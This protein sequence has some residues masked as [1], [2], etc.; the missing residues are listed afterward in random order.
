[1][2]YLVQEVQSVAIRT[3]YLLKK[4]VLRIKLDVKN[5]WNYDK[6]IRQTEHEVGIGRPW[7]AV[8]VSEER[9]AAIFY[10]RDVDACSWKDA[11]FLFLWSSSSQALLWLP[12]G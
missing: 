11:A 3:E 5:K 8:Q 4:I 2:S 10:L 1:M 7:G 9:R 6:P 12:K